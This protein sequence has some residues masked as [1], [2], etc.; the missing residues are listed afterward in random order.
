MPKNGIIDSPFSDYLVPTPGVNSGA[1]V[2]IT[3]E[4]GYKPADSSPLAP[5]RPHRHSNLD[6]GASV[7][8]TD[9]VGPDTVHKRVS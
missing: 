5:E 1:N 6:G 3:K 9:S 7:D 4:P 8:L 2:G